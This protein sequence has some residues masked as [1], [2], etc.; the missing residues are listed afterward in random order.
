MARWRRSATRCALILACAGM[1]RCA[2]LK[3]PSPPASG[4][5]F[6]SPIDRSGT[7]SMKWEKFGEGVLPMWVADCDFRSAPAIVDALRQRVEHGVYGYCVPPPSAAAAVCEYFEASHGVSIDPESVVFLPGVVQGLH[8]SC[9]CVGR[10]EGVMTHY[11]VYPPLLAQPRLAE[12][13]LV[14]LPLK[15]DPESAGERWL[16]D[17]DDMERRIE[18]GKGRVRMIILCNP[19]NPTGRVFSEAEL[20]RVVDLAVKHDLTICS[21]E[22][23]CDLVLDDE[24]RHIPTMSLSKEAADRTITLMAPSKTYNVPG[25][26]CAFA[27]IT[28]KELRTRFQRAARG[29]VTQMPALGYVGLETA[30]RECEPWRQGLLAYLR[31]N[32]R[33]LR[34]FLAEKT[35]EIVLA[36]SLE[37]TY[38]AWLDVSALKLEDPAA[39]FA[40]HG[41]GLNEGTPFGVGRACK[42]Y[43]RINFGCPERMLEEALRRL[44]K[45]VVARRAE[46]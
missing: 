21:D 46:L 20:R 5:D 33:T 13:E 26:G 7:S 28:N 8:V 42:D 40:S 18:E 19:Q 45:A 27:V 23:H 12:R 35:P 6:D 38:L 11:P 4:F 24:P 43:V 1:Q 41:I 22:I 25:L 32:R 9:K 31:G 10:G 44:E 37:A 39:Y 3:Q 15:V 16:M 14:A 2:A 34:T 17:F 36:S 30:Y 29:I